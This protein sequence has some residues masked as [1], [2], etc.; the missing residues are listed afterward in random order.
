MRGLIE[1]HSLAWW[2]LL[3][4]CAS[5]A[6]FIIVPAARQVHRY[7]FIYRNAFIDS[8]PTLVLK[9]KKLEFVGAD[10]VVVPL[11]N[12]MKF[13]FYSACDSSFLRSAVPG[14]I[15]LSN[16]Y[17][18]F[19]SKKGVSVI[20]VRNTKINADELVLPPLKIRNAITKYTP[21]I[22]IIGSLA[23][24]FFI[25][26]FFLFLTSLAAGLCT[27]I[28]AFSES[29][30]SYRSFFN[31]SNFLLLLFILCFS[32]YLVRYFWPLVAGYL[33]MNVLLYVKMIYGNPSKRL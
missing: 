24:M 20:D 11:E 7:A 15:A 21:W 22:V 8:A 32:P 10:S 23:A 33:L 17:I 30:Y 3:L 12:G 26:L 4:S 18:Y 9:D 13:I 14:S 25:F 16:D 2:A 5:M 1:R 27:I 28:D 31:L 29:I 6:Y 19:R